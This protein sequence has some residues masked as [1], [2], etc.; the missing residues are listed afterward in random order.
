M[1]NVVGVLVAVVIVFVILASRKSGVASISVPPPCG[2]GDTL[3]DCFTV[4]GSVLKHGEAITDP[5][6]GAYIYTYALN[7][8]SA[9]SSLL[10]TSVQRVR[11]IG[12]E[13]VYNVSAPTPTPLRFYAQRGTTKLELGE[14]SG[15]STPGLYPFSFALDDFEAYDTYGMQVSPSLTSSTCFP[16]T[17]AS[18]P[19]TVSRAYFNTLP[20][21]V[22]STMFYS[23]VQTINPTD[24]W[25]FSIENVPN[26]S[27]NSVML[28]R[29]PDIRV[30]VLPQYAD[31][32]ANWCSTASALTP[33]NFYPDA[34][35]RCRQR[36]V[37]RVQ[38]ESEYFS[39]TLPAVLFPGMRY[40]TCVDI[41]RDNE[42]AVVSQCPCA[43]L[44][45]T[46]NTVPVTW[47][48][49]SSEYTWEGGALN[50]VPPGHGQS[51]AISKSYLLVG[52]P[53]GHPDPAN[54]AHELGEVQL[55]VRTTSPPYSSLRV[56]PAQTIGGQYG[57]AVAIDE[58]LDYVAISNPMAVTT[59]SGGDG[60][61]YLYRTESSTLLQTLRISDAALPQSGTTDGFGWRFGDSLSLQGGV[62]VVGVSEYANGNITNVGVACVF[63]LDLMSGYF[64]F[65]TVL[66]PSAPTLAEQYFACSVAYEDSYLVVGT[67]VQTAYLFYCVMP[68]TWLAIANPLPPGYPPSSVSYYALT[69]SISLPYF[70]A[71]D[72]SA[73][74]S[75]SSYGRVYVFEILSPSD[76]R[77]FR[78]FNDTVD[79]FDTRFGM[80][81]A[82]STRNLVVGAP[83]TQPYGAAYLASLFPAACFDCDGVYAGE[84]VLNACG[85]CEVPQLN[86]TLLNIECVGCDGVPNSGLRFDYCGVCNGTNTTCLVILPAPAVLDIMCNTFGILQLYH[87]PVQNVVNWTITMAPIKGAAVVDRVT[88]NLHYAPTYGQSGLDSLVVQAN[89]AL[90]NIQNALVVIDIEISCTWCDGT[91]GPSGPVFDVCEVCGGSGLEC[92]DCNGVPNGPNMPDECGVCG[93]HSLTCIYGLV[94]A[95]VIASCETKLYVELAHKPAARYPVTWT[96]VAPFAT[97]GT[98][99]L[100]SFGQYMT[101]TPLAEQAGTD[102]I[103]WAIADVYGNT[104]S[105]VI[106]VALEETL[107]CLGVQCGAAKVDGCGVCQG[108]GN[109]CYGCDGV[110]GSG[111]FNDACGVCGGDGSKCIDCFGVPGGSA[112]LDVCGVCDGDGSTCPAGQQVSD[113][114]YWKWFVITFVGVFV[115][116]GAGKLLLYS[117]SVERKARKAKKTSPPAPPPKDG[118]LDY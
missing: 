82:L 15:C 93:G 14:V 45:P 105:G 10:Q 44:L 59:L 63:R 39:A 52:S 50:D 1:V 16:P 67:K 3:C 13:G 96:L 83:N 36:G 20:F 80:G 89:D 8:H 73:Q 17:P 9:P 57:H 104:D 56:Y 53:L 6:T 28:T 42:D 61:V 35:G 32:T 81:Q 108:A 65:E 27:L 114:D 18:P 74:V 106:T 34:C 113:R 7:T 47:L 111:V 115:L 107:D 92:L 19:D 31:Y 24:Q 95:N 76:V 79:A 94:A 22:L 109:T 5:I 90:G 116:V 26:P 66:Y 103:G 37:N 86:G 21:T 2:G 101:Y 11:F 85:Y 91:T 72:Y 84:S 71:S 68:G 87:E 102:T 49:T 48:P 100:N 33:N 55:Y 112:R 69:V 46:A 60:E 62:L 99:V 118:G 23:P 88:G 78:V 70:S 12:I 40:G 64:M 117:T 41:A 98:V 30:C 4:V 43:P 110:Y 77:L 51:V 75:P 25:L 97:K 38:Y 54:A 29:A 58:L